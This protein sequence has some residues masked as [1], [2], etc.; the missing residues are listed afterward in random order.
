MSEKYL[1]P[2]NSVRQAQEEFDRLFPGYR[3]NPLTLVIQ[4]TNHSPVTDQQ[5][6]D[7]RNKARAINGFIDQDNDPANMWQGRP[8]APGAAKDPS[9]RVLQNGLINPG[10]AP[11]KLAELQELSTPK[12]IT[13]WIGGTP[14]LEQDSIHSLFDRLP[15][16]LVV[17]LTATT[18]LMF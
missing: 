4:T 6:A 10:D 2:S 14:A 3:T 5:I 9:V 8:G 11:K 17:L 1:P 7:V 18:L 15:A 13:I 12:G 16:M